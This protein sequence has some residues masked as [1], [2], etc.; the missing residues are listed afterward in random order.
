MSD[1]YLSFDLYRP[2]ISFTP[3]LLQEYLHI[4]WKH[5][6][7]FSNPY[8]SPALPISWEEE[9]QCRVSASI[10]STLGPRFK[11]FQS[12]GPLHQF[13]TLAPDQGEWSLNA[14]D[15]R[16]EISLHF[17]L[18]AQRHDPDELGKLT[19]SIGP[20]GPWS[21]HHYTAP[22][23]PSNESDPPL[24]LSYQQIMVAFVHWA[25]ELCSLLTPLYGV[26]YNAGTDMNERFYEE[27]AR[28]TA[29]PQALQSGTLPDMAPW[30]YGKEPW[31]VY[32]SPALI[33]SRLM[34]WWS[35]LPGCSLRRLSTPGGYLRV[36][37]PAPYRY[38]NGLGWEQYYFALEA[39]KAHDIPLARRHYE[40]AIVIFRSL[41]DGD[42]Q[43][44]SL[45]RSHLAMLE[46]R[47]S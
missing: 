37:E 10:G 15:R 13:I 25:E 28:T 3:E 29:I 38:G 31:L 23:Y 46:E 6:L 12:P 14:W 44:V 18:A 21:S 30:M 42:N 20:I 2:R 36:G 35:E 33:E 34:A 7:R 4:L 40:R 41:E 32:A 22:A 17:D 24:L 5:G 43:G 16:L 26:G 45:A 39:E 11:A 8:I 47:Q 27:E 19:L 9:L 1:N